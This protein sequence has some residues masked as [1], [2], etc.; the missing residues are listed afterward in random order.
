MLEDRA[1]SS[2]K[3]GKMGRGIINKDCRHSQ[4]GGPNPLNPLDLLWIRVCLLHLYN[5]VCLVRIKEMKVLFPSSLENY[6]ELGRR[7]LEFREIVR[8]SFFSNKYRGN[9]LNLDHILL[10]PILM[11]CEVDFCLR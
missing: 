4:A 1:S 11:I 9:K 3:T 5:R 2:L 6:S 8:P 7:Y 10:I